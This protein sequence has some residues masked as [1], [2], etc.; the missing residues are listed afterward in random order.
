RRAVGGSCELEVRFAWGNGWQLETIAV[1][2]SPAA[3]DPLLGVPLAMGLPS[4][5][6]EITLADSLTPPADTVPGDPREPLR[7]TAAAATLRSAERALTFAHRSVFAAPS[8]QVG[9]ERGD[10]T[11]PV[12]TVLP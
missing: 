11:E 5:T 6:P 9:I 8:L 3:L 12:G 4:D 1:V 2:D 7:V 10:P